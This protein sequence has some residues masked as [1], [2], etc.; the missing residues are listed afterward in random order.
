MVF[1]YIA[2]SIY[3]FHDGRRFDEFAAIGKDAVGLG[4]VVYGNAVGEAADGGC[5]V[6]IVSLSV[7]HQG[8]N[9]AGFRSV[10]NFLHAHFV[11]QVNGRNVHGVNQGFFQCH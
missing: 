9:T 6:V 3:H 7:L 8:G 1:Q 10:K 5:Q 4:H 11:G 2:V